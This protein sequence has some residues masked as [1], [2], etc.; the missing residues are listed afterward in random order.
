MFIFDLFESSKKPKKDE[1]QQST[2]SSVYKDSD[3]PRVKNMLDRAY[4]ENPR[5][6]SDVE[7]LAGHMDTVDKINKKQD[8]DLAKSRKDYD[9]LHKDLLDK[10]DR[11]KAQDKRF[12]DFVDQVAKMDLTPPESARAAQ[13]LEKG[14]DVNVAQYKKAKP[15][16]GV[17]PKTGTPYGP[18]V[19]MA[20]T[21][22]NTQPAPQPMAANEPAMEPTAQAPAIEPTPAAPQAPTAQAPSAPTQVQQPSAFPNMVSQLSTPP[23]NDYGFDDVDD[24]ELPSNIVQLSKFR[25]TDPDKKTGT[26]GEES[27]T[28]IGH[29][30]QDLMSKSSN[31]EK[32]QSF[33]HNTKAFM[34]AYVKGRDV[35]LK[36][37][38]A[39]VTLT[40]DEAV[41]IYEYV[42]N[43]YRPAEKAEAEFNLL[44][45]DLTEFREIKQKV[46]E[47]QASLPLSETKNYWKKLQ[48]ERNKKL[49]SLVNELETTV[50]EGEV[51]QFPG[52]Q[53]LEQAKRLLAGLDR[54]RKSNLR[55][56]QLGQ[57]LSEIRSHLQTLGYRIRGDGSDDY[58]I[59]TE[60]NTRWK[61]DQNL[62][63][64]VDGNVKETI[65]KVKGGYRLV[66]HTGKNL[67][68][69]PSHAGAEKR[70]RQVQYFK[71]ANEE[72]VNEFVPSSND[73]DD[74]PKFLPWNEFIGDLEA[75]LGDHFAVTQ[76]VIKNSI[77]ARFIPHDPMEFGPTVLYSYYEARAGRN[78]GAVSTRGAIQVGK[79]YPNTT[80]LGKQNFITQFS[81][82]KGHPFERHF[83]LTGENVQKIY[84]III[85]NT[86]G[87]YQMQPQQGMAEDG[88]VNE[89][90]LGNYRT[91]ANKERAFA[92]MSAAFA[93]S[94]EARAK[95]KATFDK[96]ER[97]LNRVKARDERA[98]KAEQDQQLADLIARLPELKA[99]YERIS[100]EY[101]SLG[102]SN[103]QYA[104]REQNMS[105]G[106][107]KAR[108]LEGQLYNLSRQIQA[109][110]KAQG[111]NNVTEES[112]ELTSGQR[113]KVKGHAGKFIEY[114]NPK[115]AIV[116]F[117]SGYGTQQLKVPVSAIELIEKVVSEEGTEETVDDILYKLTYTYRR[118]QNA[119]YLADWI[120]DDCRTIYEL[121]RNPLKNDDMSEYLRMRKYVQGRYPDAWDNFDEHT[122]ELAQED[123][124][125]GAGDEWH[126]T[127]DAWHGGG[128]EGGAGL[129]GLTNAPEIPGL[130]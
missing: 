66:S 118:I 129:S 24:E 7:A 36:F 75:I 97:G 128:S 79:Y 125:H 59:H 98:R 114:T 63:P 86:N 90:S 53:R 21:A 89:V 44:L 58:L 10:E 93:A 47:M 18:S 88:D 4:R 19:N 25:P 54:L 74:N 109:A 122:Q 121:L 103:W 48:E 108:G 42:M 57:A 27:P 2:A 70:E 130:K 38:P 126:G 41:T 100:A 107:R 111:Q 32:R 1:L 31:S 33:D 113:V 15:K 29:M 39:W 116:E 119:D 124:W 16:T 120:K 94:P 81:L 112:A 115:V 96:R 78:K 52:G 46:K 71:H 62:Q 91:K 6:K 60:T 40:P 23:A 12:K 127:G 3:D 99:E 26:L 11:F 55:D 72:Q 105:D 49:S 30:A 37:G 95:H 56:P 5:A 61:L 84:D 82:L 64:M 87:A 9:E 28:A 50:T 80:G 85:G 34:V 67:G 117:E 102:G 68:T 106:E 77:Q 51:V 8:V 83:D 92:G 43:M 17:N 65:R 76:K 69:Y 13:D 73:R 22:G 35:K 20:T 14:K 123:S 101:K 104:D 45:S 110:E